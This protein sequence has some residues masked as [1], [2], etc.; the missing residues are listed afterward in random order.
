M[1]EEEHELGLDN[2]VEFIATRKLPEGVNQGE[3]LVFAIEVATDGLSTNIETEGERKVFRSGRAQFWT[4]HEARLQTV[5]TVIMD[6]PDEIAK[7]E[8]FIHS[9]MRGEDFIFHG[10]E[11]Q[12]WDYGFDTVEDDWRVYT[13]VFR[14]LVTD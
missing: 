12:L 2:D 9:C 3:E 4:Y 13:F 1:S 8:C 14:S 10:R 6:D 7:A 5:R 11:C